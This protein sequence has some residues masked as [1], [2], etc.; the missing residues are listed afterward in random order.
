MRTVA[1]DRFIATGK[2]DEW[3]LDVVEQMEKIDDADVGQ[4]KEAEAQASA[5]ACEPM[6]PATQE[7]SPARASPVFVEADE[8]D[9]D[10]NDDKT[11][12]VETQAKLDVEHRRQQRQTKISLA[13]RMTNGK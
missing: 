5:C 7:C 8:R 11:T 12:E 4:R 10:T 1:R 2:V 3:L 6:N 9:V 13:V